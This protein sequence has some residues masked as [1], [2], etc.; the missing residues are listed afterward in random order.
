MD[1]CSLHL[2]TTNCE[3]Y[4]EYALQDPFPLRWVIDRG[5]V[6]AGIIAEVGNSLLVQD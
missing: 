1:R 4:L 6:A 2:N 3:A 5:L